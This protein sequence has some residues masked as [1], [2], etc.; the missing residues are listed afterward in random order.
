MSGRLLLAGKYCLVSY[1]EQGSIAWSLTARREVLPGRLLPTGK[2]CLVAYCQQGSIAWSLAVSRGVLPG[3]LLPTAKYCL[4]AYC[5]EG[6]IAWSLTANREVLSGLLY[7]WTQA[8]SVYHR[9]IKN[10][11]EKKKDIAGVSCHW[12]HLEKNLFV[13]P[14]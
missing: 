9:A 3:R 8:A 7:V 4:G 10:G 11:E 13:N 1:C 12:M 2:Y 6:S 5:L 14:L